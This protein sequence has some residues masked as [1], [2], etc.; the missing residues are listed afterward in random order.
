MKK[1]IQNENT[2]V[3][4]SSL[5]ELSTSEIA[6]RLPKN[7]PP[8]SS[9]LLKGAVIFLLGAVLIYCLSQ[10]LS[11]VRGYKEADDLYGE[12]SEDWGSLDVLLG[13]KFAVSK[14]DKNSHGGTTEEYGTPTVP[15]PPSDDSDG[16]SAVLVMLKAKFD[17]LKETNSDV[18]AWI[19]VPDTLIDYPIVHT[20]NNDYYLDHSFTGDKLASGTIFADYRNQDDLSDQNTVIYGHNMASG[21]MFANLAKFKGSGFFSRTPYIYV[22]TENGIY[23]YRVFSVYETSKYDPYIRT[24]FTSKNDFIEWAKSRQS[25]SL[26]K[27]SYKFDGD[28][29]V[30]TLSTCTNGFGN[31]G[32]LAV[33]A[34]LTEIRK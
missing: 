16:S 12:M 33:H 20:D 10:I 5:A 32:R 6:P 25:K 3:F 19:T 26:R 7:Y 18:V 28:E 22:Q 17:A 11:S 21:S 15:A 2:D 13:E 1:E 31:D 9:F 30:I 4:A 14:A 27:V 24:S 34:V 23:V 8:I 29:Q